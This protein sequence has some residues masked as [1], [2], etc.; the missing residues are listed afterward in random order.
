[1]LDILQLFMDLASGDDALAEIAAHRIASFGERAI[2]ALAYLLDSEDADTRWWAVRTLALIVVTEAGAMLREALSDD[3]LAVRQCA[4]LG[5][6]TNPHVEAI[7]ALI[8][9][10]HAQDQLLRRLSADAII[11]V[12]AEAI[13]ALSEIMQ[14]GPQTARLEA[15]RALAKM[16][17]EDAIP[18][19]F[20]YMTPLKKPFYRGEREER[21]EKLKT[22]L[23]NSHHN[24]SKVQKF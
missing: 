5:L 6:R 16:K 10:L 20:A 2:A 1:M 19:L 3:D 8:A 12:G 14:S 11:A 24:L 17:I 23:K 4:A 21:R 18:I 15:V 9:S 13:P 7:P 22:R